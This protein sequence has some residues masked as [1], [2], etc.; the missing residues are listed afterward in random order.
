MKIKLTRLD[1]SNG[2][3]GEWPVNDG[4]RKLVAWSDGA[5]TTASLRREVEESLQSVPKVEL[6]TVSY[7]YRFERA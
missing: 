4:L 5:K 7:V 1:R 6:A 3:G 2:K